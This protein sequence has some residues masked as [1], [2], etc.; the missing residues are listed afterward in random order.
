MEDFLLYVGVQGI[1]P[2]LNGPKPLVLPVYDTPLRIQ[3]AFSVYRRIT[4]PSRKR[5][6]NTAINIGKSEIMKFAFG[7]VFAFRPIWG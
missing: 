2:C 4:H 3:K 7:R 5:A 1:E 6:A